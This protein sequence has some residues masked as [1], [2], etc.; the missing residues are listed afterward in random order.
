MEIVSSSIDVHLGGEAERNSRLLLEKVEFQAT[1]V[2]LVLG[3]GG[4]KL[5][6]R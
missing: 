3:F 6:G 5:Y 4:V 1:F 2:S